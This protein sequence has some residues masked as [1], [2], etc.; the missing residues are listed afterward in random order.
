MNV[1]EYLENNQTKTQIIKLIE[2]NLDLYQGIDSE[3]KIESFTGMLYNMF[4]K[5]CVQN[6]QFISLSNESIQK[7]NAQY[8]SLIKQLKEVSQINTLGKVVEIVETHRKIL[9]KIL[10]ANIYS[11]SIN[12]VLIPCSES[13]DTFQVDIL[14][15]N[16]LKLL[17]PI[18]DIGCGK[19]CSLI[20]YLK[21]SGYSKVFGIDQYE[22]GND[23][24]VTG[25]WL[26]YK[27]KENTFGT[28]ISHMA[29]SNHFNRVVL[30]E[31]SKIE[32]YTNKYFEILNSL[33]PGGLFIYT[34]VIHSVENTI[35][36][37]KFILYYYENT[38]NR[39]LDTVIIKRV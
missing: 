5:E 23:Y 39:N 25:N 18:F 27:F 37:D 13:S 30:F 2:D 28:I 31:D 17:E 10:Q 22:S 14:R 32:L 35:N 15:I 12:Q 26:D 34:P 24:I 7:I 29:F 4:V 1:I 33:K 19:N 6:N 8:Q 38:E 20:Q 11:E 16:N 21:S 36:N 9:V 3:T